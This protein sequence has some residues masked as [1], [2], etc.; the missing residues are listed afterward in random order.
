ML[1][2]N[3]GSVRDAGDG[4]LW[5]AADARGGAQLWWVRGL[6]HCGA[7]PGRG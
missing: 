6:Q 7:V 4:D 1:I 3:T 5:G 2:V